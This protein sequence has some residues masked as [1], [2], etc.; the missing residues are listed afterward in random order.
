MKRLLMIL[1]ILLAFSV[2]ASA[3]VSAPFSL[4]AGGALSIPQSPDSFKDGF[5]TGY[6]GMLGLGF[7]VAPSM[8]LIAKAELHSFQVNFGD[9]MSE[10]SGG[11]NKMWMFGGDLKVSP[12]LPAL[13]VKAYALGGAGVA[14]IKQSEFDGP[15]SL[16]L[17]I[18]N[19]MVAQDIT[20]MY[21]NVGAG[22]EL[23]AGPKLS[24]FAQARYVQIQTD[25]EASSFVPITLGFKFF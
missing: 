21:W 2:T 9:D 6:H 3:Q 5:K 11:T 18:L 17:S 7:K 13:P 1:A 22:F 4:Y 23:P 16:S 19:E 24:L 20:K 15:T 14:N 10:Y 12:S 8:Q 25:N